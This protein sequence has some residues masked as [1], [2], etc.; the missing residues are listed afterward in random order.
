MKKKKKARSKWYAG[1]VRWCCK[2]RG[3][4]QTQLLRWF[5]YVG[6]GHGGEG[7]ERE[8]ERLGNKE[9]VKGRRRRSDVAISIFSTTPLAMF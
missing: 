4:L 5:T 8:R 3:G 1:L 2:E 9:G 6:E 7:R